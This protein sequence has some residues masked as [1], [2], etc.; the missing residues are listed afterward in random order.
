MKIFID[1]EFTSLDQNARPISLG[2]ISEDQKVFYAEFSDYDQDRLL[3]GLSDFVRDNVLP[4]LWHR[5]R[6][7]K[8]EYCPNFYYGDLRAVGKMAVNWIN[9]FKEPIEIVADVGHY[10]FV[11]LLEILSKGDHIPKHIALSYH[12]LNSMIADFYKISLAE[13]FDKSRADMVQFVINSTNTLISNN[14]LFST[15]AHNALYDAWCAKLIYQY[16]K[17]HA[18]SEKDIV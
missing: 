11:L 9:Q 3:H 16:I 15:E 8:E 4:H 5:N 18:I 2:M 1:L 14:E 6:K 10:D 17:T 12:D 13:A 7:T